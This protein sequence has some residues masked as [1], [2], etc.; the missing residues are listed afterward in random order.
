MALN[1]FP[2]DFSPWEPVAAKV[3]LKADGKF[4]VF[5]TLPNPRT[6][7]D[8]KV[9]PS[10][11]LHSVMDTSG[12]LIKVSSTDHSQTFRDVGQETELE[13]SSWEG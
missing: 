6:H 11:Y 1:Y 8:K 13:L 5:H 4:S 2:I 10:G 3:K 12:H 9:L 7:I